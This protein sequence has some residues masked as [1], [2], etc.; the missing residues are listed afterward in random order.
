MDGGCNHAPLAKLEILCSVVA[1][2]MASVVVSLAGLGLLLCRLRGS[3]LVHVRASC[4]TD[5][6]IQWS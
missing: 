4:L 6:E 3:L 1:Q 2:T 5:E